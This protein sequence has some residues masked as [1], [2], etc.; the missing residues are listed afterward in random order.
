VRAFLL[1]LLAASAPSK[2]SGAINDKNWQSSPKVVAA[3]KVGDQVMAAAKAGELTHDDRQW[4]DC[5]EDD[6]ERHL[7]R[8]KSGT[9][10]LFQRAQEDEHATS[11]WQYFY[12]PKGTLRFVFL[13]GA[14][15]DGTKLDARFFFDESGK[16]IWE[17]QL[18]TGGQ[19]QWT[20]AD[21]EAAITD[22]AA[23]YAKKSI[24]LDPGNE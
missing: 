16:K 8:D 17:N 22:P 12:D 18:T 9:V 19:Y 13:T 7:F 23:A 11:Q 14:A 15:K 24:C 21:R 3:R 1:I 6:A 4:Q 10:R 20:W 5:T 2:K